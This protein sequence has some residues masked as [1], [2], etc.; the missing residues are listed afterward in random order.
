VAVF[1]AAMKCAT[2]NYQPDMHRLRSV[3]G[4]EHVVFSE[5][6]TSFPEQNFTEE[7]G[8]KVTFR[9]VTRHIM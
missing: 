8:G 7:T 6:F 2:I 5:D 9:F 4:Y 1:T 3:V